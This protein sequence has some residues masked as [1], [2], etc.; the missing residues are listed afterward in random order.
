[1]NKSMIG[2]ETSKKSNNLIQNMMGCGKERK[3][4]RKKGKNRDIE[5]DKEINKIKERKNDE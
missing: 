1:M 5:K 4:E 2:N 3:H